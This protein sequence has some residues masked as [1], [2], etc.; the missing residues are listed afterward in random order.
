MRIPSEKPVD[1]IAQ[2][3]TEKHVSS[4]CAS[5]D[6]DTYEKVHISCGRV[7]VRYLLIRVVV[8][9]TIHEFHYRLFDFRAAEG[10]KKLTRTVE[11]ASMSSFSRLQLIVTPHLAWVVSVS[12]Q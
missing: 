12:T 8:F 6:Y 7:L 5:R 10:A 2:G 1:M 11:S 4:R 3:P 9:R